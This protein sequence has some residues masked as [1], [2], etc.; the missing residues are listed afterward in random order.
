MVP[1][2]MFSQTICCVLVMLVDSSLAASPLVQPGVLAKGVRLSLRGKDTA[3]PAAMVSID[4]VTVGAQRR[5]FFRIAVLPLV[6]GDGVEIRF[7]AADAT[8]LADLAATFE[9][10]ARTEVLELRRVAWFEPGVK[11]PCLRADKVEIS[12]AKAWELTG[13]D[14]P[15]GT[16]VETARLSVAGNKA[17]T[18][19]WEHEGANA[20]TKLFN[21]P[22]S[23]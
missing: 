3:M 12:G 23:P 5:G 17:G 22:N 14:L 4:E 20:K 16:R 15:G 21:P 11:E 6:I 13:V 8:A 10:I 7:R 2:Q 1:A 9:A 19:R 18:L